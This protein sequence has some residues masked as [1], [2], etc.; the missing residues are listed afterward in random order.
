MSRD[1]CSSASCVVFDDSH[2]AK[3]ESDVPGRR[4][5]LNARRDVCT[6]TTEV[7]RANGNVE[8]GS[9]DESNGSAFGDL[10]VRDGM[11]VWVRAM[12]QSKDAMNA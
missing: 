4:R 3:D 1:R 7:Y 9:G 11:G 5:V 2:G 6:P 12:V 10:P 8:T